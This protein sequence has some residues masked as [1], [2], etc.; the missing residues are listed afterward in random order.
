MIF[1]RWGIFG[2]LTFA[3]VFLVYNSSKRLAERHERAADAKP[4]A[5]TTVSPESEHT[6]IVVACEVELTVAQR[7]IDAQ[8]NHDPL[9]RLL[10]TREIAFE[11]DAARRE[12]LSRVA[13]RWF[14]YTGTLDATELRRVVYSECESLKRP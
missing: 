4:A 14:D 5:A 8:R 1:L 11:D 9:D 12:R 2:I 6:P 3:A 13:Q 10:R 7:A